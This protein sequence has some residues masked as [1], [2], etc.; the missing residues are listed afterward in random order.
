MENL[1]REMM[2]QLLE[3]QRTD[4]S[5][6]RLDIRLATLPEQAELN[7]LAA[8]RDEVAGRHAERALELDGFTRQQN[9]FEAEI[10]QVTEKIEHERARLYS[11]DVTNPKELSSIQ[12]EL[13]ALA[14]RKTHLEDQEL[15]VMEQREEVDGAVAVLRAQIDEIDARVA[16]AMSR[17]DA[18]AADI[19]AERAELKATREKITPNLDAELLSLYETMRP[20]MSGVAVGALQDWTCRACGLPL[21]PMARQQIKSSDELLIKCENCLRLLVLA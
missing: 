15:E 2:K 3:L 10:A 21:S 1:T 7:E 16:D 13:D 17:R 18:S 19:N 9:K 20:K 8:E 4:S 5:I 12:A 6:H 14:R 11:G